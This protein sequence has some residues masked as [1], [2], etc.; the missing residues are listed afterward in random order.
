MDNLKDK[1]WDELEKIDRKEELN[2]GDLEL[3][4]KLTDTIKNID[5]ICILEESEG[6]SQDGDWTADMRGSYGTGSS[7]AN[8]GKHLVRS[9]YSRDGGSHGGYSS[10]RGGSRGGRGGYSRDD[11]RSEMMEHLEKAL[12]SASEEDREAVKRFIRQLESA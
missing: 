7:Y 12:D 4:H 2:P 3:A 6:Y 11:G 8:R 1:L 5:K 10:R 9:H